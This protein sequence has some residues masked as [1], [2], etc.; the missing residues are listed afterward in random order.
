MA[1]QPWEVPDE[2]WERLEPLIPRRVRRVRYPGRRP[3]DDR[4]VLSGILFVLSIRRRLGAVAEGARL[5]IGHEVLAPAARLAGSG[6]VEATARAVAGRVAAADKLD[7][8]RAVVDASYIQAKR[9]RAATVWGVKIRVRPGEREH[10]Q[11]ESNFR[12]PHAFERFKRL[13]RRL[14]S[15]PKAEADELKKRERQNKRPARPVKPDLEAL[16]QRLE[17][18]VSNRP[19]RRNIRP[20]KRNGAVITLMAQGYYGPRPEWLPLAPLPGV[21]QACQCFIG[22]ISDV[23]VSKC[24]FA[25]TGQRGGVP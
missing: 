17:R 1:S 13:T 10:L 21:S 9:G 15:V 20:T 23:R 18:P 19:T 2:L 14:V 22:V 8:S 4:R 16:S 3:L 12:T 25:S 24:R 6:G 5:R 11:A 7:W